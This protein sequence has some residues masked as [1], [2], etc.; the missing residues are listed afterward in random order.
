M[1]N[2][3][4]LE[5]VRKHLIVLLEDVHFPQGKLSVDA[6]VDIIEVEGISTN[7]IDIELF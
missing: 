2:F 4:A 5:I 7:G 1:R 6:V 3:E